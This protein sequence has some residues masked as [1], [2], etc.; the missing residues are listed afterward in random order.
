MAVMAVVPT[1]DKTPVQPVDAL[2]Q[3][4]VP[5]HLVPMEVVTMTV[6]TTETCAAEP[7]RSLK[8]QP[9]MVLG[10]L[11]ATTTSLAPPAVALS[12]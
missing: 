7:T 3:P 1:M 5:D 6:E 11:T 10:A 12:Q 9:T 8:T 4:I 2:S